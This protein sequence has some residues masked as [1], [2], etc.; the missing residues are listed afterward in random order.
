MKPIAKMTLAELA[1]EIAAFR[2]WLAWRKA[3]REAALLAEAIATG[4][5]TA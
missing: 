3:R 1:A 2:A 4:M 5:T